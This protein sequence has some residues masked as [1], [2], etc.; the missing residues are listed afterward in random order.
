MELVGFGRNANDYL[1]VVVVVA[2]AVFVLGI[3]MPLFLDASCWPTTVPVVYGSV[4][5]M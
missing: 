3:G 5:S 1:Y 2:V 4:V